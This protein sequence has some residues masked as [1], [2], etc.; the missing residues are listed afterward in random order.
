MTTL[1]PPSPIP[2]VYRRGRLPGIRL[3]SYPATTV[4]GAKPC[5][6]RKEGESFPCPIPTLARESLSYWVVSDRSHSYSHTR[7]DAKE[8]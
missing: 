4:V 3:S 2:H 5:I 1:P 7:A 6:H 8:R